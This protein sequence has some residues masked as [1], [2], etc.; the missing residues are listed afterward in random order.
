MD[1][2]NITQPAPSESTVGEPMATPEQKKQLLDL[3]DASQAKLSELNAIRLS[4]KNTSE[5]TRLDAL[6]GVFV[7]LQ[8][9][10]VDLND[11]QSVSAFIEKIREMNPELATQ[12]E[13]SL[14][15][16]LGDAEEAEPAEEVPAVN[17]SLLPDETM[18]TNNYETLP[19]D[20]PGS[21]R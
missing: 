7:L 4:G 19:E 16:L 2:E 13:E 9:A 12:F 10:G 11:P 14:N 1:P 18:N 15:A 20:I 6:K 5:R 8:Q 21:I 17:E 3:I